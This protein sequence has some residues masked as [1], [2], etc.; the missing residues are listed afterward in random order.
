M[1]ER[2][3]EKETLKR[4]QYPGTYQV[5]LWLPSLLMMKMKRLVI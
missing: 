5:T 2:A 4:A 1:E 3:D